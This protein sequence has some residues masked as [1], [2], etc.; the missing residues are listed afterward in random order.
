MIGYDLYTPT[1]ICVGDAIDLSMTWRL[2]QPLN[3]YYHLFVQLLTDDQSQ[4]VT[5]IDKQ[6]RQKQ[7]TLH[8]Q[9]PDMIYPSDTFTLTTDSSIQAGDYLAHYWLI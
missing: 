2:R 7:A 9:V 1:D 4:A 8:W 6:P 5:G 3:R